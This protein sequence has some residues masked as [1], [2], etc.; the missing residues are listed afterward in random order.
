MAIPTAT[1]TAAAPA[2]IAEAVTA[3]PAV[4]VGILIIPAIERVAS[5]AG[6]IAVRR[7]LLGVGD[8]IGRSRSDAPC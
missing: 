7:R 5:A 1:V 8:G 3:V 4:G 6:V 2:A